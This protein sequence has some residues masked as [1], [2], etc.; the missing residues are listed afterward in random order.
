[1][2]SAYEIN[3]PFGDIYTVITQNN[4]WDNAIVG[5]KPVFVKNDE[6]IYD[7]EEENLFDGGNEY[8][9]SIVKVCDI[10]L[11]ELKI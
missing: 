1:M 11:K 6:L 5:L 3:N 7:Y 8:R 10:F 2:H 4:R 9:F